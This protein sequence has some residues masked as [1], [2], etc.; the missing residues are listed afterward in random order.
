MRGVLGEMRGGLGEMRG[1]LGEMRGGL[2]EEVTRLPFLHFFVV[3][4]VIT[5]KICRVTIIAIITAKFPRI[6]Q[7]VASL[8]I[9]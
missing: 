7:G 8:I 5:I 9:L 2:G 4:N 3:E 1:V 6:V